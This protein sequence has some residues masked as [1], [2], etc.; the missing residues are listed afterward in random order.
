[1]VDARRSIRE[2]SIPSGYASRYGLSAF[3][4]PVCSESSRG[5]AGLVGGGGVCCGLSHAPRTT[6]A[7]HAG[8]TTRSVISRLVLVLRLALVAPPTEPEVRGLEVVLGRRAG[9]EPRPEVGPRVQSVAA[10]DSVKQVLQ[11][12]GPKLVRLAL[13]LSSRLLAERGQDRRNRLLGSA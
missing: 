13:P 5:G 10:A 7:S 4:P 11:L 3:A 9:H 12:F 1:S 2:P 6:S 8:Q